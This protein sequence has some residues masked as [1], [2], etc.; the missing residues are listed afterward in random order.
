[1]RNVLFIIALSF[2]AISVSAYTGTVVTSGGLPLN[3]RASPNTRGTIL[4][5]IGTGANFELSCYV[6]GEVVPGIVTAQTGVWY[7]VPSRKGYVHGGFVKAPKVPLC[8]GSNPS[9]TPTR[10]CSGGLKNPRTCA[11][12]VAWAE[13][14]LT[15]NFVAAYNGMCDYVVALAYGR[16]YSGFA[17]A[18]V[19]WNSTPAQF[20]HY[21]R[22]PPPGALVFF[23]N[24]VFGHIALSTGGGNIISTDIPRQG[25]L[26]RT[27]ID[28][29]DKHNRNPYLGWTNPFY[30]NA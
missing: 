18:Q 27:T 29:I 5:V 22:N 19:H 15:N 8:S 11:Q 25:A 23:Q 28:F 12:A 24:G 10:D 13:A 17:S 3:V 30:H 7:Y 1:M 16:P 6:N 9:P 4:G 2:V 26:G 20:K 14:H 21:D